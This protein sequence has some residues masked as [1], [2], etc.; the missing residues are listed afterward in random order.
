MTNVCFTL[1]FCIG[2]D[3]GGRFLALASHKINKRTKTA[4]QKTQ[5]DTHVDSEG[6]GRKRIE[7]NEEC[8]CCLHVC[9][10]FKNL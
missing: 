2:R 3:T 10:Y 8:V 5:R 4:P 6:A 9:V 7:S 1:N